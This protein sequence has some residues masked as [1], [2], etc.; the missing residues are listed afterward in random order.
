MTHYEYGAHRVNW[1]MLGLTC[2]LAA[3]C[4]W[5]IWTENR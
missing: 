5:L 1:L 3:W 4:V 2:A